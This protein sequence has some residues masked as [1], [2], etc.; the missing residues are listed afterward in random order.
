MLH[1]QLKRMKSVYNPNA[2]PMP[3]NRKEPGEKKR[4]PVFLNRTNMIA[5]EVSDWVLCFV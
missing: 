2:A 5:S 4:P 3:I 1:A